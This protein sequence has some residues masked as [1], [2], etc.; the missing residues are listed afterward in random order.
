M[1]NS[2]DFS[3]QSVDPLEVDSADAMIFSELGIAVV[4]AD[5]GQVR[6]FAHSVE[7][8]GTIQSISPELVHRILQQ[9]D[10]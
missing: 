4:T 5:R 8:R 7:D 3:N 1:A 10:T 9:Q 2:R 6:S